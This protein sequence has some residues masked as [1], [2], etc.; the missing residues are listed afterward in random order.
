[1][2]LRELALLEERELDSADFSRVEVI[3]DEDVDRL[4]SLL[5]LLWVSS[6]G[7][8]TAIVRGTARCL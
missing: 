4:F 6:E 8:D 5:L 2:G 7:V 1:M 3:A